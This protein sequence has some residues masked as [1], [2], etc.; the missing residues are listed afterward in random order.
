MAAER[1]YVV[2]R[3]RHVAAPPEAV[4]G[5]LVDFRRWRS[6][7]PWE[8]VDPDL[9]RT[10]GG[11]E[12]GVGARYAWAGNRKAGK[13]R[14][15]IEEVDDR[16]VVI[17]LQFLAPFKSR[18]TT[19]FLLE[20]TEGGTNV[21]WR[22]TGPATLMTRVMGLFTSMDKLIGPDFEKGLDRLAT[23]AEGRDR[24]VGDPSGG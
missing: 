14:M 23:E 17:D 16:R 8:E 4:R 13:G 6:W 7:S 18:S 24:P 21:T 12:S 9:H 2:E 5:H 22:M 11:P 10:Y 20:R 19:E 3:Q 1:T 15:E